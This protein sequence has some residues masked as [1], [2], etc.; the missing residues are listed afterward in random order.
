MPLQ[1]HGQCMPQSLCGV[2]VQ[3]DSMGDLHFDLAGGVGGRVQAEVQNQFL[4]GAGNAAEIGVA[5]VGIGITD[6]HFLDLLIFAALGFFLCFA[7]VLL[8]PR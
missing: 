6:D 5:G 3:D 8:L 4:R 2:V 1:C 7:H